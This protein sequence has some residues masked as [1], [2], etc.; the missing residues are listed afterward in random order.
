MP[1]RRDPLAA[2]VP[3]KTAKPHA[4]SARRLRRSEP[5]EGG[6]RRR[7]KRTSASPRRRSRARST[8]GRVLW[9]RGD[10]GPSRRSAP[11]RYDRMR[12]RRRCRLLCSCLVLAIC[13]TGGA[14]LVETCT[15]CRAG[16]AAHACAAVRGRRQLAWPCASFSASRNRASIRSRPRFQK[17]GSLRSKPIIST[18][19]CGSREPPAASIAR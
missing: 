2:A 17:S 15:R 12:I 4:R 9:R 10:D 18:S 14:L 3:P 11:T 7:R 16:I 5:T 19:L 8:T 13:E 1:V 6:H